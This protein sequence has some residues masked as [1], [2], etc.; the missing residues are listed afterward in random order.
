MVAPGASSLP[1]PLMKKMVAMRVRPATAIAEFASSE[2]FEFEF[3]LIILS[4][5]WMTED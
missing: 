2:T 3:M 5:E 4:S 1:T